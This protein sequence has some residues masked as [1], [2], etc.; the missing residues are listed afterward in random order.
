MGI[1]DEMQADLLEAFLEEGSFFVPSKLTRPSPVGW[2]AEGS[3]PLVQDVRAFRDTYSSQDRSAGNIP[4]TDVKIMVLQRN[5][6]GETVEVQKGDTIEVDGKWV[7]VS[8]PDQDPAK[9]TWTAQ[10]RRVAGTG[11]SRG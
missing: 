1:L 11:V 9:A 5:D 3:A 4:D 2:E 6:A 7:V 10:C 8:I